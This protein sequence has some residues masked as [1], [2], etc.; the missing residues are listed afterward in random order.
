L[1]ENIGGSNVQLTSDELSEIR[2]I[3]DSIE[4]IGSRY[5]E[6][7]MAVSIRN[8]SIRYLYVYLNLNNN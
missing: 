1:E 4:I 3:I 8:S 6:Q 7:H 5:P 2:K